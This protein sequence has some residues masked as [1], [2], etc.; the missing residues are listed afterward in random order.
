[1]RTEASLLKK[2]ESAQT[3]AE[4]RKWVAELMRFRKARS[5]QVAAERELDLAEAII[6]DVTTPA[7]VHELHTAATDWLDEVV[8]SSDDYDIQMRAKATTWF[9]NLH[10]AVVADRD[11]FAEQAMGMARRESGRYGEYAEEAYQDFLRQASRQWKQ[12]VEFAPGEVDEE[13][14]GNA[15]ST[16]TDYD[17]EGSDSDPMFSEDLDGEDDTGSQIGSGVH[18][19]MPGAQGSDLDPEI[20][21]NLSTARRK[22]QWIDARKQAGMPSAASLRKRAEENPTCPEC[23][24]PG[25]ATA[26]TGPMNEPKVVYECSNGHS[27][28]VTAKTA[29]GQGIHLD[30]GPTDS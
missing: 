30:S 11:E 7:P 20:F 24:E 5:E 27:W 19:E 4:K 1:M 28:R 6:R 12:A 10:P 25:Y 3:L 22:R 9:K 2:I 16:V 17:T 13:Q 15:E 18:P 14:S 8:A 21:D 26:A 29:A 23:G